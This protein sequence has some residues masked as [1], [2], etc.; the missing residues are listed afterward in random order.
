MFDTNL[1]KYAQLTYL[2]NELFDRK[3]IN[4]VNN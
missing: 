2:N 1:R 4:C 3:L